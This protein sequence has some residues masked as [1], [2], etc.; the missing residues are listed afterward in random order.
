MTKEYKIIGVGKGTRVTYTSLKD[1][2]LAIEKN[3]IEPAGDNTYVGIQ[4]IKI[5]YTFVY[6]NYTF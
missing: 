2:K 1:A 3:K 6:I 5:V 4:K